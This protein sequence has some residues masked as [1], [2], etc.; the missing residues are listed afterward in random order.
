MLSHQGKYFIG[1]G[2]NIMKLLQLIGTCILLGSCFGCASIITGSGPQTLTIVTNPSEADVSIVDNASGTIITK[3]KSPFTATLEKTGNFTHGASYSV[4]FTKPN[5]M[6]EEVSITSSVSGWY[7]GN[8]LFG[9]LIG[10]IV[11]GT[12]GSM[13]TLNNAPIFVK[14]YLDSLEGRMLKAIEQ[15][16]SDSQLKKGEYDTTIEIASQAISLYPEYSDAYL[17]RAL[18]YIAKT[19]YKNAINDYNRLL[20]L[21]PKHYNAILARADLHS[22]MGNID[23]AIADYCKAISLKPDNAELL[24]SRG[25]LYRKQNKDD[26]AKSDFKIA[27]DMGYSPACSD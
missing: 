9:G 8:A 19:E 5:Y 21:E 15:F 16:N 2:F 22:K 24:Y 1:Y 17:N 6:I 11:D 27:C 12:T 18:A 7:W 25:Q 14:L 3:V 13:Y 20:Q 23:K 26:L 10:I 4:I